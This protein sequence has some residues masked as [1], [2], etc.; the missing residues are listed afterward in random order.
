MEIKL[1]VFTSTFDLLI[2]QTFVDQMF[3]RQNFL[4]TCRLT[5]WTLLTHCQKPPTKNNGHVRTGSFWRLFIRI[6][7]EDSQGHF[8]TG[9][10][11]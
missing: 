6:Q 7:S 3:T 8:L 11:K 1:I 10:S 9:E 4:S 2:V 5:I